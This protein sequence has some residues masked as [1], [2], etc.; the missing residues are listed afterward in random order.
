MADTRKSDGQTGGS[1]RRSSG[2]GDRADQEGEAALGRGIFGG[3]GKDVS[4]EVIA[5]VI[6]Q[7][8]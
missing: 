7:G 8:M 1:L 2:G 6:T 5:K 4:S 3:V